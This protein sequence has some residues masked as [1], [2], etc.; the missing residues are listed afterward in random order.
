VKKKKDLA[1]YMDLPYVVEIHPDP[2]G[3]GLAAI[4]PLLPGC[5]TQGESIVELWKNV[6]DAK[7]LWLEVAIEDGMEIPEPAVMME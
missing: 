2:D 5:M 3:K 6:N 7:R 1:Y 4:I